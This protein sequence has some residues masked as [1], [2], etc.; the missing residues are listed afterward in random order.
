MKIF[1][2]LVLYRELLQSLQVHIHLISY[3]YF[4]TTV[5]KTA[6]LCMRIPTLVTNGGHVLQIP[7]RGPT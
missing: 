3:V 1:R 4:I 2:F 5:T 7:W 6:S